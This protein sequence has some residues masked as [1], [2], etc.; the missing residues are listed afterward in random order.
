M[1]I[2]AHCLV[3]AGA[4][5]LSSGGH[6]LKD[7]LA[8]ELAVRGLDNEIKI[9]ETGC[10]GPCDLGPVMLVHP[11]GTF[12]Q[13]VTAHDV[14]K[15]V[16]EHFIKGR[17]YAKLLPKEEVSGNIVTTQR[18][19]AFFAKQEKIILENCGIIDAENVEEYIARD[20]YAALGKVLTSMKPAEVIA[21]IKASGLRGRGGAGFPTGVKWGLMADATATPKYIIC[22]ADEGDPGAFMNRAVLEGDPHRVLEG[23][24]IGAYAMGAHRGF[25]YIRAE[26]PLAIKR[27]HI[28]IDQAYRYGL[29][30]KNLFD[31]GFDFGIE[32]RIGAGAFVCGE[33]TAMMRSI[34]GRR[35][36]PQPR[37]P[38]PAQRGLWG[39]PTNINNVETWGAVPVIIRRGAA[40]YSSIGT[41]KCSGTKVFALA[42]KIRN[43]GL[44]E[45][46]YGTTLRDIIF[47]LGGGIP[48]GKQ[49]KAV[50]TGGPSGGVVPGEHL[51]T[52]VDYE[53]LQKLGS[54]MGS[55]GMVIMD[56]DSCMVNIARFF[57]EFC[58]DESCGKCPPCRVGTRQMLNILDRITQG[59]AE[60]ADL[61]KLEDLSMV[62]KDASLCG[63]GQTA[64]NPVLTT[65]RYFRQEYEEHIRERRCP[66]GVCENLFVSPCENSCPLHMNIPGYLQLLKEGRLDEAFELVIMDNP[67]PATTGRVCEHPC[68]TRCRRKTLD[69]AVNMREVHR[70]I[71]DAIFSETTVEKVV[72][73]INQRKMAATGKRVG[74]VGSGPAGLSAAFYLALLGHTVTV[75]DSAEEPGGMLRYALPDYRLPTDILEREIALIRGVGVG[76]VCNTALGRDL[77]L[78]KLTSDHDAVFLAIGTWAGQDLGVPGGE[79]KGVYRALDFLN[80]VSHGEKIDVGRNVAV[81][82]G[83]NAAVDSA[84]TALRLGAEVTIVY[85][86]TRKEMPAIVQETEEALEEGVKLI[87]L[88]APVRVVGENGRVAGIEVAKTVL[89]KYDSRGRRQPVTTDE[90]YIIPCD[91]VIEAIGEKVESAVA[92]KLGL[93]LTASG[94][95]KVDPWTL[96]TANPKV[97]AGGDAVTGAGNVATAM[98]FGKKA[99]AI[100]DR[101][102][103]GMDR[104]R[105]LWP[106]P[107][108]DNTVPPHSAESPRQ[109]GKL[110]PSNA[111]RNTWDEVAQTLSAWEAR[112]EA[113][114]CLR[115]DIKAPVDGENGHDTHDH[116]LQPMVKA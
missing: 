25:I 73:R 63:L 97:Y 108:Y 69:S 104:F 19:F 89:G 102:L 115:C 76:F 80:R 50:Q 68:E 36:Q 44:V 37:P 51:D 6:A 82:G 12:Y 100:I 105:Q 57:M 93:P 62:V 110:I 40:W 53:S 24:A 46:P 103:V 2:R 92:G 4:G 41:E 33:E 8:H 42:G 96:Q 90:K 49:F 67:L 17:P 23:M 11:D 84:R 60:L 64:P 66:A 116:N 31:S 98:G 75:F 107:K 114:R 27:L 26:Y 45:V 101:Q 28:A 94:T 16:E 112:S 88:A 55:G 7:A 38:F 78:E 83:G 54:I 87:T 10:M 1:M 65:L 48:G 52:P 106:R 9:V 86:R 77:M 20:G 5:C 85:R 47:E 95:I 79:L 15:L 99:A 111:R 74:I 70:Y 34:E 21:E 81:I 59:H 39:K 14:P 43:T 61:K 109:V 3:C 18:D 35:G 56:E 29:L 71:A 72:E 113:M 91:M 30:G 32:I 22:N 13:Q 58:C